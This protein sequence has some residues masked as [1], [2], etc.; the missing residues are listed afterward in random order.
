MCTAKW[1]SST[2]AYVY[3][4]VSF[5]SNARHYRI[6]N[7]IPVLNCRFFFAI[8]YVVVYIHQSQSPNLPFPP[9]LLPGNHK[10]LL[11]SYKF[12]Y[13]F[14]NKFICAFFLID[15]T[16]K[17][18]Y[19]SFFVLLHSDLHLVLFLFFSFFFFLSVVLDNV[20]ISFFCM[21][22]SGLPWPVIEVTVFSRL[23]ILAPFV[24]DW[25]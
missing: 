1:I 4:F 16:Y 20:L 19:I 18:Y 2:Y 9:T 3:P 21:Q 10:L 12:N 22:L 8:L 15:S 11:V 5:Y 23:Y 14:V 25:L 13:C 17:R 6:F 24:D 7:R